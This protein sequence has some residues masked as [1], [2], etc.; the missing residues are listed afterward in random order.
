M[1][2]AIQL[3]RTRVVT[4]QALQWTGENITA[5]QVLIA[6]ASPLWATGEKN[7]GIKIETQGRGNYGLPHELQFVEPGDWIVKYPSGRIG[8]TKAA[9]FE[10]YYTPVEPVAAVTD[11]QPATE[12]DEMTV[13][14]R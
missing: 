12:A 4:A 10:E 6:P 8:I 2:A 11:R 3:Y 9:Q 14:E 5:V 13:S 1:T 7:I